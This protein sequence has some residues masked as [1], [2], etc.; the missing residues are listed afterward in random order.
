[1]YWKFPK[2]RKYSVTKKTTTKLKNVS[3]HCLFL[4]TINNFNKILADRRDAPSDIVVDD[5]IACHSSISV[6]DFNKDNMIS[7]YNTPSDNLLCWILSRTD[8]VKV[9]CWL[10]SFHWWRKT[11]CASPCIISGTSGYLSWSSDVT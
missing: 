1:M 11:S 8:I 5:I 4:F 6:A 9:I 7:H 2:W 3:L 10:P